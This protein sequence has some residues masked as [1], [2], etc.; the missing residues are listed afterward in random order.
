MRLPTVR[1]VIDRR[2]LVNFRLDPAVAARALPAPFRPKLVGGWAMAGI[3]LIRLTRVRPAWV[4][5]WLA[6]AVG[7]GS[8]NAAHR[9]AVEWDSGGGGE[10]VYVPRRDTDSRLAALAG[11][12]LFPGE[13]RHA[14]FDVEESADRLRVGFESDDGVAA[15]SVTG[16]VAAGLPA[17]S[18]FE[19]VEAASRFFEAVSLGYSATRDAGRFDGLEL[20]VGNW[21]VRPLA[22]EAVASSYFGDA[23]RFPPGSVAFDH[24]LLMRGIDDEWHAREDLC[25]GAR[26]GA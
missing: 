22:V 8:E 13:H 20:R 21:S 12:R 17:K 25:C 19:S 3:C 18:T 2:I 15:V 26:A 16:R 1:G 4:P 24:A 6:G 14:R 11:G 5:G 23:E 10:G 9:F 7:V